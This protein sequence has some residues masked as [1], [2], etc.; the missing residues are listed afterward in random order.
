[1][2][3]I[4][5]E[6]EHYLKLSEFLEKEINKAILRDVWLDRFQ[7]FWENNP[8]FKDRETLRGWLIIDDQKQIA[9]VFGYVP[10][11]YEVAG[12]RKLAA[13]A[14]SWF[15]RFD[16]RHQPA[17]YSMQ[18]MRGFLKAGCFQLCTTPSGTVKRIFT[19][20]FGF[21]S[22]SLPW[23]DKE[24]IIPVNTITFGKMFSSQLT[25][26]FGALVGYLS[27][28]VIFCIVKIFVFCK[29][30]TKIKVNLKKEGYTTKIITEFDNAYNDFWQA[31]RKYYGVLAVRDKKALNWFFFSTES[32][33]RSRKVIELRRDGKIV[34]YAAFKLVVQV[35]NNKRFSYYD[36]ADAALIDESP[37]AWQCL[38]E[39]F[40]KEALEEGGIAFIKAYSLRLQDK[41]AFKQIGSF[42]KRSKTI[43]LIRDEE[44]LTSNLK[45]FTT[46]LDG[47]RC[48]FP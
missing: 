9:G 25:K 23:V 39:A 10:V 45:I 11:E 4:V 26:R 42:T 44:K 31:L 43:F 15:V 27:W 40:Y 48:F 36:L 5:L 19:S 16:Y 22:L 38:M 2:K 18:V 32:L 28:P 29:K 30:I 1:M 34:G 13:S 20:R 41:Y 21:S 14:T 24:F 17:E 37:V 12:E 33:K 8:Y 47:D 3:I 6:K 7:C 46:P 35:Y